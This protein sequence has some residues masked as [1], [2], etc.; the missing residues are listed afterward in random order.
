MTTSLYRHTIYDNN[1]IIYHFH[2]QV[3][4][5]RYVEMETDH[6]NVWSNRIIQV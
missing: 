1:F 2:E 6:H 3:E 4:I 5:T